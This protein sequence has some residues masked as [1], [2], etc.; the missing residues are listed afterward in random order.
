[1]LIN[2]RRFAT[3]ILATLG[4][5]ASIV[6]GCLYDRPAYCDRQETVTLA[7]LCEITV[8]GLQHA[9]VECVPQEFGECI[10]PEEVGSAFQALDD[11]VE[12]DEENTF[13]GAWCFVE[14]KLGPEGQECCYG[15][16]R[17]PDVDCAAGRPFTA[18]GAAH[19]A[20]LEASAAWQSRSFA[21]VEMSPSARAT[22]AAH[23]AEDALFEHASIASFARFIL[24]LLAVGAPP[25]LVRD[26]Q[27]ALAD[28]IAHAELCFALA[29]RYAGTPLG[30]GALALPESALERR[31]LASI[32]A[33]AVREGCTGETV[34]A[35]IAEAAAE[36]ASD[37]EVKRAMRRIAAEETR[38]AEL[39]F[40]FVAW[41]IERGGAE[42]RG[43]VAAAFAEPPSIAAQAWPA[44]SEAVLRA[45]GRLSPGERRS[46]AAAAYAEVIRPCARALLD[47]Q[48][49]ATFAAAA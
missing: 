6:T 19:I 25:A 43:A 40:R 47:K 2:T 41:A 27:R 45:H 24:E 36:Q 9:A 30:P 31:D 26:A 39:A 7:P 22:L 16:V 17:G 3:G 5:T 33:A 15:V 32:A 35:L 4:L 10:A 49:S 42:V 12:V 1:M 44:E 8:Y 48:A 14:A 46:V 21:A 23:Y 13:N 38:H 11:E 20:P 37:P 34:S 18:S 28:E 29:S